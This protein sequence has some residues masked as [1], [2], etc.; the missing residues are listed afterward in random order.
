MRALGTVTL[1]V[2]LGAAFGCSEDSR[3]ARGGADASSAGGSGGGSPQSGS[4]GGGSSRGGSGADGSSSDGS[5]VPHVPPSRRAACRAYLTAACE[6]LAECSRTSPSESCLSRLGECPDYVFSD[7]STRTP[8][9]VIACAAEWKTFPCDKAEIGISPSCA[10]PGTR[11]PS[12]SCLYPTQCASL[13]C[14]NAGT[15]ACGICR[16][17]A[18]LGGS[19]NNADVGCAPGQVC[20]GGK[21]EE[22]TWTPPVTRDAAP[23]PGPGVACQYVTGCVAGYECLRD[24]TDTSILTCRKLPQAGE[25]CAVST[26][27]TRVCADGAYCPAPPAPD[28]VAEPVAGEPCRAGGGAWRCAAGHVCDTRSDGGVTRICVAE[29]EEGETC[30]DPY[31]SCVAGTECRNRRCVATDALALFERVC[32]G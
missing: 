10:R 27:F 7:G 5:S 31:V 8:E 29:H 24:D 28:C 21:C 6:R 2:V 19:C 22:R 3:S 9:G 26:D 23:P 16:S 18:A 30:G 4:G 20:S 12:E 13:N 17:V 32:G 1:V 14:G 25:K 15:E 11:T